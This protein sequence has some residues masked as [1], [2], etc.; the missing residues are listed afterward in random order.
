MNSIQQIIKNYINDQ[1]SIVIKI[2]ALEE[3]IQEEKKYH[4]Q[5]EII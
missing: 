3:Q 1:A 4:L 2:K 5:K